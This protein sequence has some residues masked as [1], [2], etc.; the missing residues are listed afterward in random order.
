MAE[1]LDF[2]AAEVETFAR[3]ENGQVAIVEAQQ[4]VLAKLRA[5]AR[6]A[7]SHHEGMS[8]VGMHEGVLRR[9]DSGDVSLVET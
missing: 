8:T 2:E 1:T 5:G 4:A 6:Y 9:R 3:Q 7:I